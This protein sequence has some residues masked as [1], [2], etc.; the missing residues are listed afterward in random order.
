MYAK[1]FWSVIINVLVNITDNKHI[2]DNEY[3][4]YEGRV[5]E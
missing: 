4:S 1:G 3:M 5:E 2:G